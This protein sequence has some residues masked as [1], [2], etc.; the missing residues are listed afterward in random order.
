MKILWFSIFVVVF[1]APFFY[2]YEDGQLSHRE[3]AYPDSLFVKIDGLDIHY[4]IFGKNDRYMILLHG[5]GSNT[6]TWEKVAGKLSQY[7]TVIAY[8]RPAFGLTER[9]FDLKFNPYTNEY[10]I[11]LLKKIMD[12]FNIPKA[13]LVGNSAGGFIALNFAL[14]YPEK[15][16][17]LVLADAAVFNTD[18]TNVFIRFLMNIP[19]VN[20]V[21]P[22]VVGR[23][24]QR[25]FEEAL[26]GA[27]FDPSKITD[28]DKEAYTRPTKVLGW[29]KALWEFTKAAKYKDITQDLAKINCPVLIIHGRQDRLISVK[30]SEELAK[31][32]KNATL[33]IIDNCGHVPQEECPEEFL[34]CVIKRLVE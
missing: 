23:L 18:P 9:R 31:R 17:A 34:E 10:Q 26:S 12:H 1:F 4:K 21:G 7:Y 3:L 25:S 19:Q 6:Y 32:L 13:I 14:T 5:F 2:F 28:Q 30:D 22:D 33:C 16:E 11:E 20:H 15:V 8:D 24:I 29:K 27:Y